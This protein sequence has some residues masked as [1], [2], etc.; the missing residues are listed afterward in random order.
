MRVVLLL[1]L[2]T[3]LYSAV[4]PI[5][6]IQ[7]DLHAPQ[8]V[9]PDASASFSYHLTNISHAP[10]AM[11]L[12][13]QHFQSM[14]I[15]LE[16][17][18]EETE[19]ES[20]GGVWGPNTEEVLATN[21]KHIHISGLKPLD[22]AYRLGWPKRKHVILFQNEGYVRRITL[23]KGWIDEDKAPGRTH[24]FIAF[25]A[26]PA[27]M[28][29]TPVLKPD[30]VVPHKPVKFDKPQN[31]YA[32]GTRLLPY[33]YKSTNKLTQIERRGLFDE[34]FEVSIEI[35]QKPQSGADLTAIYMVGNAGT[36]TVWIEQNKLIPAY[37]DWVLKQKG[38]TVSSIPGAD[39]LDLAQLLPQRQAIPLNPGE[40][41]SWR[42]VLLASELPIKSRRIYDLS[43]QISIPYALEAGGELKTCVASAQSRLKIP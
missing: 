18:K 19:V 28:M 15:Y 9:S 6:F 39:L 11:G 4:K 40:Y 25:G 3:G 1:L 14:L 31:A 10:V 42:R 34:V 37:A 13:S 23:E 8:P 7:V 21:L 2:I 30:A 22:N 33:E 16:R 26:S 35:H 24:K 36:K 12:E 5:G 32:P 43:L 38:R 17:L 29:A 41:L 20:E 27:L